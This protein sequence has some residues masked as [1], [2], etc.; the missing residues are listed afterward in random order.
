[1]IL[2]TGATGVVGQE[3]AAQLLAKG[4][5]FRAMVRDLARGAAILG[6]DVEL[7][8][9]DFSQP[10]SLAP[11]MAGIERLYLL[12]VAAPAMVE[13]E[14]GAVQAAREAGIA[15]IVKMSAI[16]AAPDAPTAIRR[17]HGLIEKEIEDADLA[18]THLWPNAFM[19][20]F[21]R[22][23]PFIKSEGV[24]YAPLGDAKVSLVDV[25]DVAAVSVAT[26][27]EPGHENRVYEITGPTAISYGEAAALLSEAIGKPVRFD[28]VSLAAAHQ[29][30]V[31]AGLP[32]WLSEALIE[33]DTLF[34]DGFGAPVTSVVPD[35]TGRP[36]RDFA[37]FARENTDIFQD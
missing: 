4:A 17:W 5:P 18:Y 3:L 24:F 16:R 36:A 31:D 9:G 28:S 26:L 35:V 7:V 19:Q 11:A 34:L 25:Y 32:D 12:C 13:L 8:Y 37:T 22:F 2:L 15:H 27:T 33:I 29:A 21:R 6:P 20:N 1:M 14:I 23:A 30:L 10:E